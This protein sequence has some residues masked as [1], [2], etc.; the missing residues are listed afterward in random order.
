MMVNNINALKRGKDKMAI[1][2]HTLNGGNI[3]ITTGGS[4]P[5]EPT[6]PNGKVLYKTSPDGNWLESANYA[7]ITDGAFNGFDEK[8]D[9]VAVIIPSKDASGNDV[10][11]IGEE[12]FYACD[13]LTS[14]TIPNSVTSIGEYVF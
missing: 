12:A 6:A 9:A 13:S 2:I 1:Y 4:T 14:V 10:T 3:T 8:G 11:S 5:S 7:D